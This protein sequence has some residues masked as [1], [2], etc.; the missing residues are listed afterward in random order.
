MLYP[1]S[2]QYRDVYN[3]N[4]IWDFKC[5]EE[6]YEPKEKA[7]ESSPMAVPASYND[8]VT[9]KTQKNHEG[10]VLFER[11]FSLPVREENLY[12]LR[13][14]ATSHKCEIYLN[15]TLI[16]K[17]INGYYPID[18]PLE[19]LQNSNRLSVVIDNRLTRE[20]LPVGEIVDGKQI[21]NHD[22]YNFTGI[23]RDVLVY[24]LPKKHIEDITI[25]TVVNGDYSLINVAVETGCKQVVCTVQD[26]N[27]NV[28]AKGG[29][30]DLKINSPRTWS[31]ESPYLYTLVVETESDIYQET[32]GIR[33]VEVKGD[34]FLL[35][36]KPVYFKGFG[37]HE[38]FIVSGKGA[39]NA[40]NV[41]NF[42]LL[43]WINANSIRTSHYPYSED[44]MYLADKYGYMVI[45]EVPAV[46]MHRFGGPLKI[47]SGDRA[48]V[49][50]NTKVLH[51]ELIKQLVARDKNHPCVVMLCVGNE[52][53]V[54]EEECYEY[55]KDIF[56]YARSVWELPITM[57]HCGFA[58]SEKNCGLL[59]DVICLNRYYAWY[60][61]HHGETE[62]IGGLL[63]REL[64]TYYERYHKPIMLTEYGADTIEGLH[65]LPSETFS[66]EYQV[67]TIEEYSK[68][69][70]ELEYFI[71]E[72][73][74]AFADF[75]TKQGL[76]RIRG[77]RKGV[78]TKD[79]QPKMIAHYLKNRW[80]DKK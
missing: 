73:V 24:T 6:N 65:T 59:P 61:M 1:R 30:G 27:G 20:S 32:F 16:G 17:G 19:N 33:K 52:P 11:E 26:E 45:D 51:K 28:V 4:G 42:E 22:F 50:E 66:E 7:K 55:F 25:K 70:D 10:K 67:E 15:G 68:V 18:L 3:L 35:N 31:P 38:D 80:K 62:E 12:R 39:N 44:I 40:V 48:L 74:W 57:V 54:E 72:H 56:S 14:G 71:G 23:H 60:Y 34:Q 78:F 79:R 21:T 64:Q 9:D 69:F 29:V 43:K 41:R 37:M 76:T 36:D 58:S 8:I 2:N 49:D 5:V 13:I 63:K 77:N 53:A 46:G 75:K 47:F